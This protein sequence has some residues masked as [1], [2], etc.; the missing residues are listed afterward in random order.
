M[1]RERREHAHEGLDRL[2]QDRDRRRPLDRADLLAFFAD[3]RA[4]ARAGE[5]YSSLTSSIIEETAR[6]RWILSKSALTRLIVRASC[7]AGHA[8]RRS[9]R[10]WMARGSLPRRWSRP[11]NRSGAR[12]GQEAPAP[13]QSGVGP[14]DFLFRRRDEHH[15]E[16]SAS[17]PNPIMSSG[18]TTLP[19]DF[20]MTWPFFSTMPCVSSR[21]N[22]SLRSSCPRSRKTPVKKRE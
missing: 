21:A 14:L 5:A 17:A 22:G 8:R 20:D 4:A 6:L 11:A 19:F 15:V 16:R 12:R 2:L 9:A 13:L 10:T 1:R 18:S 7:A 3:R